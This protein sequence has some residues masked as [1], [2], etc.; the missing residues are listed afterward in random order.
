MASIGE[1]FKDKRES[2]GLTLKD[3]EKSTNIRKRYLEAIENDDFDV[4]PGSAYVKGFMRVYASFLK[5]DSEP[6]IKEFES[7]YKEPLKYEKER[8][9]D[10]SRKSVYRRRRITFLLS[11]IGVLLVIVL[12]VLG[13]RALSRRSDVVSEPEE[14]IEVPLEEVL[15]PEE[16]SMREESLPPIEKS[17]NDIFS[18]KDAH[19]LDIPTREGFKIKVTALD[20]IW[21]RVFVDGENV[22]ERILEKDESR[23]WT[24]KES[25][26]IKSGNGELVQ[27]EKDGE[28]LGKLGV[29]LEEKTFTFE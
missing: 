28:L 23:E 16:E 2:L 9:I 17:S 14:K 12:I 15:P 18:S 13:V 26:A 6:L 1:I 8:Y 7:N 22:F 10:V 25:V 21:L 3:V 24:A 19:I 20:R 4:I 11:A 5:I 27:V 29:G